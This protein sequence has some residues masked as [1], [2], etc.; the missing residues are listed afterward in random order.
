[1]IFVPTTVSLG[2]AG[3]V[4]RLLC[5]LLLALI[6]QVSQHRLSRPFERRQVLLYRLPDYFHVDSEL[7]MYH[8]VARSGG[9][10]PGDVW[11]LVSQP[12]GNLTCRFADDGQRSYDG[13]DFFPR[14]LET[15][16]NLHP[17]QTAQPYRS[18]R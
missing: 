3:A 12:L 16:R 1:M 10:T 7:P 11:I 8:T 6:A 4:E 14:C 17:R 13:V 5:A 18:C 15:A 2:A 9:L